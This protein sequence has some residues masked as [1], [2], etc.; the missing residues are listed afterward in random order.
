MDAL[1]PSL[2][3][4]GLPQ[5]V[6]AATAGLAILLA[7]LSQALAK[8]PAG[9][10]VTAIV[11]Q[12]LPPPDPAAAKTPQGT[13]VQISTP[14]GPA[15]VRIPLATPVPVGARLEI[16]VAADGPQPQWRLLTIN[17]RPVPQTS[18]YLA[19]P[20]P[21]SPPAPQVATAAAE[22]APPRPTPAPGIPAA[23]VKSTDPAIPNGTTLLV[24]ITGLTPA[25][26][27]SQ[28]SPPAPATAASPATA[29]S[30]AS[31]PPAANNP[32][33]TPASAPSPTP[34]MAS[35]PQPPSQPAATPSPPPIANAPPPQ[36]SQPQ[37]TQPAP[38]AAT[39]SATVEPLPQSAPAAGAAQTPAQ[40]PAPETEPPA[41][42]APAPQAPASAQQPAPAQPTAPQ[43]VA[44][45]PPAATRPPP[46]P[47]SATTPAPTAA[48]PV[49]GPAPAL[50]PAP[51]PAAVPSP[52][53]AAP[54]T[55][56]S[57]LPPAPISPRGQSP[58]PIAAAPASPPVPAQISGEILPNTDTGRPLVKTS[59]G[60]LALT[61]DPQSAP[62]P[63]AR[64]TLAVIGKPV[65][66]GP[67]PLP[68]MPPEDPPDKALPRRLAQLIEQVQAAPGGDKLA[69]AVRQAI[70]APGPRL[71]AQ[72]L[73]VITA[74]AEP[75]Q[76][77]PRLLGDGIAAALTHAAPQAMEALAR[78]W[79]AI[80]QPV[81]GPGDGEWRTLL[82]PLMM[83]QQAALM[84]LTT[85]RHRRGATAAE[86]EKGTRFLLDLD[87]SRLGPMQFDGL[88]KRQ[89]KRFDLI[90]R[91]REPLPGEMR[92]DIDG[93]F[94]NGLL[95]FGLEGSISFQP[96]GR[97]I[98][99]PPLAGD[100]TGIIFA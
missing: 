14:D 48:A 50:A 81:Q 97:F 99:T 39:Q 59:I 93:L 100:T 40:A 2:P 42:A 75:A 79:E 46:A 20:P 41:S 85:R 21:S 66:P 65:P 95:N 98:A 4:A 45:P 74:S 57:A 56:V 69:E 29:P 47:V 27:P 33:P 26:L 34:S 36:Q 67:Q 23:L 61:V 88:V 60:L 62:P 19:A 94:L 7:D 73:A 12:L 90:I 91:T 43:A 64:V 38:Q 3:N 76:A 96:D 24:R 15:Q 10:V 11:T 89:H 44:P 77:L 31:A 1:P 22:I 68:A 28:P 63:G 53:V 6:P 8:L 80:S 86:R 49:P 71:A 30:P 9:S 35:E 5:P 25:P 87:L 78:Q 83:G 82:I 54:P 55:P 92:R 32:A 70:P 52:P 16:A 84:R 58:A 18:I 37:Q 72:L 13:L 51:A 17:D